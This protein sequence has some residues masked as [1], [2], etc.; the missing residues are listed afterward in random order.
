V[1]VVVSG[2]VGPRGGHALAQGDPLTPEQRRN[3]ELVAVA[4]ARTGVFAQLGGLPLGS[5][6]ALAG[7]LSQDVALDRALRLW[8]RALPRN[9]EIRV[10][11]DGVAEADVRLAPADLA[12]H[13]VQLA[14]EFPAAATAA[15]VDARRLEAAAR[16]WPVLWG[17]GRAEQPVEAPRAPGWEGVSTED[18]EAARAAAGADA[19]A[20]LLD[21]AGRLKV[22]SARRVRE[23]LDSSPAVRA[24]VES[25]LRRAA[26]VQVEFAPDQ[27]V[28]VHARLDAKD[29]L[30]ILTRVHQAEYQGDEFAAADFR[31]MALQS[32]LAELSATGLGTPPNPA[33]FQ[34]RFAGVDLDVPAWAAQTLSATG[35]FR[36]AADAALDAAALE[37]A[38]RL[39]ALEQLYSVA[40]RLVLQG[41][42]TVADYLTYHH[43]LKPDVALWLSGAHVTRTPTNLPGGVVE[44][45]VELPA[46]RLWEILRRNMKVIEVVPPEPVPTTAPA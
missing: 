30:R 20:A 36:P 9:G 4:R 44:V 19:Y 10:Y 43:D 25:E 34:D 5:G 3:L 12:A 42:V 26:H 22:T 45:Q 14:A 35:R 28:V 11:A 15:R 32:D 31:A 6:L 2:L 33:R 39:D 27:V 37:Q 1:L 13:L 17:T 41:G 18:L 21:A 8:T 7:W 29:L 40:E 24:A 38:A 46:R 23:F 16:H